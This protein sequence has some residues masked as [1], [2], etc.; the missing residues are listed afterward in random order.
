MDGNVKNE[1]RG[2]RMRKKENETKKNQKKTGIHLEPMRS[3]K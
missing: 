3:M 2:G 1:I